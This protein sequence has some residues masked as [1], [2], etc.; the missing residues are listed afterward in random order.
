MARNNRGGR[1]MKKALKV[2]GI[3]LLVLLLVVAI[4][5]NFFAG[6]VVKTAVNAGGPAVLGV[7]VHL[8][9][10]TVRLIRG[11][12]DIKGL[13][14]GNPEGFKSKDMF[15]LD[16]F[17]VK[18]QPLS[19]MGDKIHIEEIVI[20]APIIIYEM[21]MTGS[22]IGELIDSL[23]PDAPKEEKPKQEKPKK[24]TGQAK[25]VQIDRFVLSNAKIKLT[26]KLLRGKGMTLPLPTVVLTDIG[27]DEPMS[28][29]GAIQEVVVAVGSSVVI[30]VK[31]SGKLLGD[32]GKALGG[33]A[34]G[35]GGTAVDGGK[36]A[37][38]AVT[39]GAGKVIGGIGGLFKKGNKESPE[40]VPEE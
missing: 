25:Q 32:G 40:P 12:V 24:K 11:L 10:A 37:A 31:S 29:A 23:S 27:K 7:P 5:V 30:V 2:M 1:Q 20:D 33:A 36:A 6:N 3:S 22:N 39:E 9:A 4:V 19:V 35:A 15:K 28:L 38:G 18:M 13:N 17:R 14:I 16:K 34:A 8:D 26:S 21:S